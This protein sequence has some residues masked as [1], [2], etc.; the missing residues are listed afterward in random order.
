M[1]VVY[2]RVCGSIRNLAMPHNVSGV[3][4]GGW[5]IEEYVSGH[6]MPCFASG[7]SKSVRRRY[8]SGHAMPCCLSDVSKSGWEHT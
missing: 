1:Q 8:A 5:R 2:Q 4:R 7:V 3:P 6:G